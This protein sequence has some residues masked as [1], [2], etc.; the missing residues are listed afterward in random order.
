[1]FTRHNRR[2]VS[3]GVKTPRTTSTHK[4]SA[5]PT[6]GEVG[7]GFESAELRQ[8]DL[9][10]FVEKVSLDFF[11]RP[12]THQA[13]YNN[14]LQTTAG[15][16]HLAD[17]HIDFNPKMAHRADF[18]GIVK[19]ELT[20]YHLHL[21]HRGYQH[22]DAD[23]KK[24]LQQVGGSRYAP[25]LEPRKQQSVKWHYRCQNGHDFYRKRRVD[26]KKYRCGQCRTQLTLVEEM[27]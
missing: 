20:H 12:F 14:R 16:Y 13:I 6:R 21:A 27:R 17:H 22:K 7:R 23:F 24:L 26:T 15:R 9:Q 1:M 8:V 4:K 11:G 19:H 3:P 2:R 5:S 25:A 10:A 18:I